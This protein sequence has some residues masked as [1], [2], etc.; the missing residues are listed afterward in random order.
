MPI[1]HVSLP[2]GPS[3]FA[4]MREFYIQ[5][6]T[7]LGYRIFMEHDKAVIGFVQKHA[8]PDF[9]IHCGDTEHEKFGGSLEKRGGK[10]HVAFTAKSK[11]E[12]DRWYAAAM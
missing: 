4:A 8:G 7:P 3:N 1:A 9:W 12:V 6:L 11:A 2:T 5:I 10:T